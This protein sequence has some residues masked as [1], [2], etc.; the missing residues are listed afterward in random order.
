MP[1]AVA[2]R[3]PAFGLYEGAVIAQGENIH[4]GER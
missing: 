2:R 1:S 3:L 4:T